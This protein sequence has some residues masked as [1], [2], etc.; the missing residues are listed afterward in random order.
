M[1]SGLDF[2]VKLGL[3]GGITAVAA[4]FTW[5]YT[6]IHPDGEYAEAEL[7]GF[8]ERNLALLGKLDR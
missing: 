1:G 6:I 7:I 3:S 2:I 5:L 4:T 8:L